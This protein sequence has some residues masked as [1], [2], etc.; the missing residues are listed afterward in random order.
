M[1]LV[2][3][4]LIIAPVPC[5]A[6]YDFEGIPLKTIATGEVT[7]DVLTFGQYGLQDPPV[8]LQF[9]IPNQIQWA[10]T[11]VAVWGGTPRYT[12]W[13][14]IEVNNGTIQKT[15]LFGKDD[16]NEN[17]YVT[18]YGVYWVAYDTTTQL[19]T[20]HNTVVATTS[21]AD[22]NNKLDGRIY[23]VLTVVVV[24]DPRGSSTRYWIAEGNENLHGEGWSGT[25]PTR[26][27]E[28]SITF[29]VSDIVGISSANLT[30]LHLAT[31]K[32]QPD[33]IVFN[34][35]DLGMDVT[36]T[37]HYP[38]SARDIGDETSFNAGYQN[39]VES[40]Y[41]DMEVFDVAGFVKSGNNEV[42]FQR[43]RDL[44]G[45]G[46]ITTT[47][48]KPEGEDYIHPVFAMLTLQ[49]PRKVASGPD[50]VVDV[51]TVKDAY[52]GETAGITATL[53]NL[54]AT[55]SSPA[56]VIFSVDGKEIARKEIAVDKSGIQQVSDDW[57]A[58][59]GQ[60]TIHVD[61]SI[62]GD[63]DTSNNLAKKEISVGSLP[64]LAISI[65]QPIPAGGAGQ[66]QKSPMEVGIIIGAIVTVGLM[67]VFRRRP[68]GKLPGALHAL[69]VLGLILLIIT[70]GFAVIPTPASAA[71]TTRSY[72]LPVII[73]NLGGSDAA[74]FTI[75]VYIDGEKVATKSVGDGL[76][77]GKEIMGEIPVHTSP[78]S[79]VVKV[80]VDEEGRI[81]ESSRANNSA[82][83]TYAFP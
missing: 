63:I 70:A 19:R 72:T 43:G 4:F 68:P 76:K 22:P 5:S 23:A 39:P 71:D 56:T 51:I 35:K 42:K 10:R 7:G 74:A 40:R 47:G 11:Y 30:C 80:V 34:G 78:G 8:T 81:R 69:P 67:I 48:E 17:V 79:H 3:C 50:L 57:K 28:T 31:T 1:L 46:E 33:Y 25:T 15:L 18:G 45:D 20:G 61:A 55:P 54:G 60:H 66:Q 21:R 41:A 52:E 59:T 38:K 49:K 83:S 62:A 37:A 82:G 75:T 58:T 64:D 16:K 36:D 9:D 14:G 53:L 29:P 77:A 13:A 26:H 73:K 27:E 12:G 2:I 32:G 6:M 44:N 24:K 65:N